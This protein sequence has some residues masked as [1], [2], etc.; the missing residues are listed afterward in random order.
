MPSGP[1]SVSLSDSD[2]AVFHH[3]TKGKPNFRNYQSL[4]SF[5]LGG[6][7]IQFPVKKKAVKLVS[8]C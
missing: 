2:G 3:G 7:M 4:V 5:E 6:S 1:D 8:K